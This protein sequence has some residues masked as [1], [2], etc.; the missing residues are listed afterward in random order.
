[1]AHQSSRLQA[2]EAVIDSIDE[3]I[4][5]QTS[6]VFLVLKLD[7]QS[8]H[9][10]FQ[11]TRA[12]FARVSSSVKEEDKPHIIPRQNKASRKKRREKSAHLKFNQ[13][14]KSRN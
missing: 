14:K 1:M 6:T 12:N 8:R 7:F 4:T 11:N 10:V 9:Q 5:Y 13:P 3:F 2:L